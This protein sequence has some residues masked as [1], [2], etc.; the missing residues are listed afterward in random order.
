[1][2]NLG[3]SDSGV[4]IDNVSVKLPVTS[5]DDKYNEL[6]QDYY[7]GVNYPNPFNP[8]TIINYELPITNYVDLSIFD[9]LGQK[10]ATLIET[11]QQ[12]GSYQVEWDA[13]GFASGVYYYRIQAGEFQ[14]VKK[15]ILI[16]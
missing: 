5:I 2:I 6:P 9:V 10:V 12:P 13:S 16:R 8:K 15:M 4:I 3:D 11:K 7:L 14:D 1:M